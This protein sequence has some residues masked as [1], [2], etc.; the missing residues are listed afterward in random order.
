MVLNFIA[1]IFESEE[2]TGFTVIFY[3]LNHSDD[4]QGTYDG[5]FE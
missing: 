1:C 5:T 2:I 3:D 4:W